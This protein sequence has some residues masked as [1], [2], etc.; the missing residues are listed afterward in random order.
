MKSNF[1]STLF[2]FCSDQHA[3]CLYHSRSCQKCLVALN[4]LFQM[5]KIL[6]LIFATIAILY[7]SA[8]VLV[9]SCSSA[10]FTV[11]DS[12]LWAGRRLSG[13]FGVETHI[14]L[15]PHCSNNDQIRTCESQHVKAGLVALESNLR[16]QADEQVKRLCLWFSPPAN[17]SRSEHP[18][19]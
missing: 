18:A 14:R 13:G 10:K 1:S 6:M 5:V 12:R 8:A 19:S 16:F 2:P 15:T 3:K 17:Q 11:W 9:L 7:S 4:D